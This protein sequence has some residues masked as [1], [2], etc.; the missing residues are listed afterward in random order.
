MTITITIDQDGNARQLIGESMPSL[1]GSLGDVTL[2]RASHVEPVNPML[3]VAFYALRIFGDGGKLAGFTRSWACQWQVNLSPI[4]LG[5]LP[6][7]YHN[8]QS[9]I[10]AEIDYLTRHWL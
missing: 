2:R 7:T 10:D 1:I 4:G 3:R 8:R 6:M 5:L 9:A